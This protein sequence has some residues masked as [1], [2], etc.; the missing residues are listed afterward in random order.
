MKNTS[1]TVVATLFFVALSCAS[2]VGAYAQTAWSVDKSHS[3]V[4][5]SVSHLVVSEADGVFKSFT[6]TVSAKDDAFSDAKIDFAVDVAS[7]NTDDEKRDAHLKSDD[8]FNA[9]K[10]PQMK[11]VSKS[12][13]KAGKNTFKLGGDLTIRDVTKPVTFDVTLGGVVKDPWGNTK[14]GFKAKTVINRFD[15]NLKWTAAIEG[16]GLV[17]GKDVTIALNI[18]LTKAKAPDAK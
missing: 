18:E 8:F 15:Y 5:F 14:A 13:K 12:W 7:I 17:V 10:F 3:A 4:K 9:E 1:K 2:F 11:F 16:G 6:G